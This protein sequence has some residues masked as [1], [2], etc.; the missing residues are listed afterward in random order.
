MKRLWSAFISRLVFWITPKAPAPPLTPGC[1]ECG[2][3]RSAH[4]EGRH[5]CQASVGKPGYV[6]ACDVYIPRNDGGNVAVPTPSPEDLE[7]MYG[8]KNV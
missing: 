1:C 8:G 6:C 3:I 2:H 7:R 4:R 5:Y